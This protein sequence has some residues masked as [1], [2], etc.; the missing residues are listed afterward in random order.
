VSVT[1]LP[2]K[3]RLRGWLHAYSAP[4]V[5]LAGLTL[6]VIAPTVPARISCAIYTVTSV[7]LFGTSGLYHRTNLSPG[8]TEVLRRLDHSNIYLIIAG[9]YTPFAVVAL[10]GGA[11]LAVLLIIWIGAAAGVAFRMVWL[12]APRWLY[13]SLYIG[14]GWVA[15]FF[16]PQF[17]DSVG[18]AA[19]ILVGIGGLLYSA[20]AVVYGLKRPNP[21]PAWF[22]FH[23]VFHLLTVAAY[24]CQFV[25]VLLVVLSA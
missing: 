23:E 20:G 17:L 2:F 25:A 11:R 5:L 4:V 18:L 9:T 1:D 22:G 10:D 6:I 13:T 21:V 12:S 19:V 15:I 3:P 14:L 8:I 24:V 16:I 7:L